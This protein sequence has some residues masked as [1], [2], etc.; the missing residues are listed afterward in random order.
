M[1]ND[2]PV[3]ASIV[4]T[5]VVAPGAGAV[6]VATVPFVV[7]VGPGATTVASTAPGSADS[8][9]AARAATANSAVHITIR[10]RIAVPPRTEYEFDDA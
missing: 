6:T 7:T 4:C 3:R 5:A 8:P 10:R 9:Q 1:A 2:C